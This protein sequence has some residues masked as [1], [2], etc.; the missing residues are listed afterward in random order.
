MNA[1]IVCG[2]LSTRL[3]EITKN[4][5]KVLLKIKDKTVLE[6]QIEKLRSLGISEVVLAAGHLAQVLYKQ[7]GLHLNGVNFI[8]AIES[9]PLGT[10]GAIKNAWHYLTRVRDPV[11]ILNG[12]ILTTID[13]ADMAGCLRPMTDGIILGAKVPDTASYGTLEYDNR[14]HLRSFREKEGKHTPGFINGSVYLFNQQVQKYFPTQATFS[15]EYD[16]FP[17]MTNLFVY[18][19]D[20]PWVDIGSPERLAW[21]RENW[22]E[23]VK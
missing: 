1:I 9:E 4:I 20:R 21:A 17:R 8:Y 22:N 7:I 18:Q 19:S 5:P 16:I 10:G 6:W 14:F 15:M 11:L 2:G 12:D 3:G 13:L 23:N